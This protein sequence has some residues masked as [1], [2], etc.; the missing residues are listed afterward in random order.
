MATADVPPFDRAPWTATPCCRPTRRAPPPGAPVLAAPA[1]RDLHRRGAAARRRPRHL[2][3]DRHRA[4]LPAG[5]DAV[6]MVERTRRR[7]R[8]RRV[9]GAAGARAER[10]TPRRRP[11]RRR[12]RCCATVTYLTPARLGALA[13]AGLRRASRSTG[14][15]WSSSPRPATRS[16]C[17]ARRSAP[18]QI[19][20]INRFTLPPMIRAHGGDVR[21]LPTRSPTT[22]PP[23][24]RR[25]RRAADAESPRLP[26]GSSVGER[27]LL[28]DVVRARGEII[29]H[30]IAVKPGKPTMFARARRGS[31][32]RAD[33]VVLGLPGNPTSCLSN[34]YILLIPLLRAMARLPA[35]RPQTRHAAARR[36]RSPHASGR[37]LFLPVRVEDGE[38]VPAFKGSGEITSLSEADGLRRD[39]GRRGAR[40]GGVAGDGDDVLRSPTAY[41][42]SMTGS[43]DGSDLRSVGRASIALSRRGVA[44][45]RAEVLAP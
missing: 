20:D 1:R 11:R 24:R 9:H 44:E 45:A 8:R 18:G 6:V 13:A 34:A 10:R 40:R 26:G 23:S 25:S 4:P 28:V 43:R 14:A 31:T 22:S 29:F 7:E 39:P 21:V 32:S 17:P 37:H 42:L 2:R 38:A 3:R 41:R 16:S 15:R 36:A 12:R 30:G 35:W 19:H 5:A 33:P 27:D